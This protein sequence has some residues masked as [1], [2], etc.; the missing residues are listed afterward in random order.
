MNI[1]KNIK[2]EFIQEKAIENELLRKVRLS[3]LIGY[4]TCVTFTVMGCFSW[5]QGN[6][7]LASADFLGLFFFFGILVWSKLTKN[8]QLPTYF[9]TVFFGIFCL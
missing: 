4:T 5:I 3:N 8:S 1:K 2:P 6:Y 7:L 9:G